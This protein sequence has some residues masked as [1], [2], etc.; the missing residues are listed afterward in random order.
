[1][2]FNKPSVSVLEFNFEVGELIFSYSLCPSLKIFRPVQI[3]VLHLQ[4][5]CLWS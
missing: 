5:C 3:D 1:M 4:L 2:K